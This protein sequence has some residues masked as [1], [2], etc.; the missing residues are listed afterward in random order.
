MNDM[1][2][3][4]NRGTPFLAF[5]ALEVTDLVRH[6]FSVREG[7]VS[8]GHYTSMN[9]SFTMGDFSENVLQNY[10]RMAQALGMELSQM[11]SVWQAHTSNIKVIEALD[12]GKGITRPKD[13]E[14]IDGMVTNM[15]GVTLVTLHADCLPLYLLDPVNQAIGLTHSGWRGTQKAI[16]IRTLEAMEQAFGSRREDVM[17]CIGPGIGRTAFEVG[18]DVVE[19]FV[20]L[21][22]ENRANDV[23]MPLQLGTSMLDLTLANEMLFLESGIRPEHLYSADLCT[24]SRPDLFFSHRRDGNARGSM[25]AFL[26]LK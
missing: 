23:L 3:R 1:T 25:A 21:L 18:P 8:A 9:L 5:P 2:L 26:S 4:T 17:V 24:Y 13:P 7:G 22:G 15:K 16:G 14:Q 11:T 20:E 10:D 6:G 12:I 19:A